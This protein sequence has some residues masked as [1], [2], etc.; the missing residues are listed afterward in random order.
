MS[1]SKSTSLCVTCLSTLF[2]IKTSTNNKSLAKEFSKILIFQ[3]FG[4]V[5]KGFE[6]FFDADSESLHFSVG[7]G[8]GIGLGLGYDS[9]Y[10]LGLGFGLGSGFGSEIRALGLQK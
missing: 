9:G 6:V 10:W 1:K 8:F 7:L 4:Y 3:Y 2:V 5:M